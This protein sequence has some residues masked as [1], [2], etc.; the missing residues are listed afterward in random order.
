MKIISEN[1]KE[2]KELKRALLDNLSARGLTGIQYT[3]KVSEYMSLWLDLQKLKA[4]I[5]QR[6]VS[7][8][9]AKGEIKENRSISLKCQVS[10]QMSV[11]W[12]DL[13]FKNMTESAVIPEEG[14]DEL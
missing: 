14:T 11:L 8:Q 6:G 9:N 1:C 3:D 2:Y 4:D 13:G 12:K 7:L 5:K 10:K